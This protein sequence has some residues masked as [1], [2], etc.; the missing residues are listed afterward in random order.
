M[1]HAT[2]LKRLLVW[3][4]GITLLASPAL[5]GSTPMADVLCTVMDWMTGNMGKGLATIGVTSLGI[6]AVLGKTSWGMAV[7]VGVGIAV[8]FNAEYIVYLL[9]L[10]VTPCNAL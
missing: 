8:L 7:T 3:A 5:A 1:N 4:A 2:A 6:G 10:P 9:G